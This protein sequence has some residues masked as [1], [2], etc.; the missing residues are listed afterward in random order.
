MMLV[1]KEIG[2]NSKFTSITASH[3]KEQVASIY[4]QIVSTLLKEYFELK[5]RKYE[6]FEDMRPEED[7][8]QLFFEQN[9]Q[10]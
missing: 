8:K 9:I 4:N 10:E 2:L 7:Q 1:T 5:S 6:Y 3:I